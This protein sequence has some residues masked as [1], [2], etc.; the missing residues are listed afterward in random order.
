MSQ[1]QFVLFFVALFA[2]TLT[3][4]FAV[5]LPPAPTGEV[6]DLKPDPDL[7]I[8][9]WRRPWTGPDIPLTYGFQTRSNF[10]EQIALSPAVR[11][12]SYLFVKWLTPQSGAQIEGEVSYGLSPDALTEISRC[13]PKRY[14]YG[15]GTQAEYTSGPIFQCPIGPLEPRKSYF[16]RIS[17]SNKVYNFTSMPRPGFKKF[18]FGLIADVGQTVNSSSTFDHVASADL[19]FIILAGDL[20]YADNY[21]D[22]SCQPYR[23]PGTDHGFG[24]CGVG[25]ARWDSWS[26]LAQKVFAHTPAAY[27]PGNHENEFNM[28]WGEKE[29]F[30]AFLARTPKLLDDDGPFNHHSQYVDMNSLPKRTWFANSPLFYSLD[31]GPAHVIALSSYSAFTRYTHQDNFLREDLCNIDREVTPWLIVFVHTPWYNSDLSHYLEGEPFRVIYEPYL[32]NAS[33]DIVIAGH[34]HAYERS[35]PVYNM[36]LEPCGPI[37]VTVGDGGNDEG[38]AGPFLEPQPAYSA[39]REGSFGY[40]ELAIESASKAKYTWYR[41]QNSTRVVGDSFDLEN[42]HTKCGPKTPSFCSIVKATM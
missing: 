32:Y 42:K 23:G 10:P 26:R 30:K 19:D 24:T 29:P 13:T 4:T 3:P 16:Y 5:Q 28:R 8:P 12:G 34:V 14:S 27:C 9:E 20:T 17:G 1:S 33:T 38:V 25:G 6:Y 11:D 15:L 22:A 39:Y 31:T 18:T 21:K 41:N 36:R 40:A 35:H 7:K 2:A 37:Y